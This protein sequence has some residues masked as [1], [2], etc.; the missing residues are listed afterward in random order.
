MTVAFRPGYPEVSERN[1]SFSAI[2]GT[3]RL[4]D[5]DPGMQIPAVTT[6]ADWAARLHAARPSADDR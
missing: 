4:T 6:I 1:K 3:G 5:G 2:A